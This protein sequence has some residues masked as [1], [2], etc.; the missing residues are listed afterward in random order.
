MET[1]T[2]SG[3]IGCFT[4]LGLIFVTLKLIRVQPVAEWSWI[5]VLAPFWAPITVVIVVAV[6]I[7]IFMRP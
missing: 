3:G 2:S 4:A 5:W 6:L 1:S 7:I